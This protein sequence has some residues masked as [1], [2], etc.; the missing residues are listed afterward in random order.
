MH[1]WWRARAMRAIIA[2][3]DLGVE[4]LHCKLKLATPKAILLV[5][6]GLELGVFRLLQF[7]EASRR[8]PA[9]KEFLTT[10]TIAISVLSDYGSRRRCKPL[11]TGTKLSHTHGRR[12]FSK[13]DLPSLT[14][15]TRAPGSWTWQL[16]DTGRSGQCPECP[17]MSHPLV[18]N[19]NRAAG[20]ATS[21]AGTG[22]RRRSSRANGCDRS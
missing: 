21:G 7:G 11:Q 9:T 2:A 18:R 16:W 19:A 3:A 15:R 14:R 12:A 5:E 13:A 1:H 8:E 20:T 4:L 10:L 6:Q 22:L 17:T